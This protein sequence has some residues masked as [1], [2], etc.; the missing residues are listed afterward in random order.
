MMT[1]DINVVGI[2]YTNLSLN[3]YLLK[4]VALY[5]E[6][7]RGEREREREREIEREREFSSSA[8]MSVET[9]GLWF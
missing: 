2:S 5:K 6:T 1:K 7:R 4:M 8:G 3:F 9:G